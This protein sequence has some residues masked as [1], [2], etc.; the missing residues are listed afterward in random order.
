MHI[1]NAPVACALAQM[2]L[3]QR[4]ANAP[5]D[6]V[7]LTVS[8]GVGAG[9]V[10]NGEVVRG[11]GET[12]QYLGVGIASLINALNPSQIMVGGE[13]TEYWDRLEPTIREI[14]SARALTA[15]AAATPIL[16]EPAGEYPRLRGATAIVSAPLFAAPRV[17]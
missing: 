12:A 4:G 13:I 11:S 2:W 1:E 3:G 15:A 16:T 8:D 5:S 6:F 10:V 14:V 7:Y 17:A 9:V